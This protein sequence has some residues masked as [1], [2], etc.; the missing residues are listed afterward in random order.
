MIFL[1]RAKQSH[2]KQGKPKPF[3]Y[4]LSEQPHIYSVCCII[5]YCSFSV[6]APD[7][8]FGGN[9]VVGVQLAQKMCLA[10]DS[11][12]PQC[13]KTLMANHSRTALLDFLLLTIFILIINSYRKLFGWYCAGTAPSLPLSQLENSLERERPN[14]LSRQPFSFL[15][16][17]VAG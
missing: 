9:E 4:Q 5:L 6:S 16:S 12:S 8:G 14:S 1:T 10:Q 3:I 13:Y 2:F 11:K 15:I 17:K 7:W